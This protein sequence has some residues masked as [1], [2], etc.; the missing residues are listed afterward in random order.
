[1]CLVEGLLP[2]LQ[3]SGEGMDVHCYPHK[4]LRSG[5]P[6]RSGDGRKERIPQER[7]SAF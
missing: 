5:Y 6:S 1:M 2:S 4:N 3:Q 7:I